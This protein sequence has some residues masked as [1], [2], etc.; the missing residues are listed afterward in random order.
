MDTIIYTFVISLLIGAFIGIE[1]QM[2]AVDERGKTNHVGIRTFALITTLGTLSGF[3]HSQN[4]ILSLF[5]S[6]GILLLIICYYL[7]DSFYTKD[8]GITTEITLFFSYIIGFLLSKNIF[9][10][11][12][13]IGMSVVLVLVLSLK[14]RLSFY[15]KLLNKK[16]LQSFISYAVIAL[17]ILPLLPNYSYHITD[18]P[19]GSEM[20]RSLGLPVSLLHTV[21]I[22]NPF[23]LWLVV[24]LITGIDVLGYFLEKIFGNKKGWFLTSFVGG[25]I[26]STATTQTLAQ[27]SK[28]STATTIFVVAAITATL[29]SF[30]EHALILLPMNVYLFVNVIPIL[31]VMAAVSG[32]L[33]YFFNK[34]QEQIIKQR[35]EKLQKKE[36]FHLYP[37][38][39]FALLFVLVKFV[40][41]IALTLFGSGG[42]YLAIGLGAIPGMDA[43][44]ITIAQT[45]G[46]TVTFQTALF[47]FIIANAVN[48][49]VKC[50]LTFWQGK[51]SFAI[52]FSISAGLIILSGFLTVLAEIS[53]F[54]ALQ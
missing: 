10:M 25:F 30:F 48:L 33:M 28:V 39:K 3:I 43:V 53:I 15:T 42:F 11:P 20:L 12:F 1:R 17:V 51:R 23:Q 50:V 29:A 14:E 46:K 18:L 26:S 21:E 27:Q 5:I 35:V 6:S 22:V 24:A 40:S 4:P 45:A 13:V 2:H 38:I 41:S 47:A 31:V 8:Y 34:Q 16:E 44:L 37:A 52:R 19:Y 32:I 36:L 54:S 7:F 9:T 49:F